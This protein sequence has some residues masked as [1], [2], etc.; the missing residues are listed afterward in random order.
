LLLVYPTY[1]RQPIRLCGEA[2]L[3]G[4]LIGNVERD[5]ITR[6]VST[7][8]F[9]WLTVA[10]VT[11]AGVIWLSMLGTVPVVRISRAIDIAVP[12]WYMATAFPILGMLVADIAML[13]VSY[14][15]GL[16]WIELAGQIIVLVIVSSLRLSLKLPISGHALLFSYFILR[17]AVIP[18]PRHR[19]RKLESAIA[20]G[21]LLIVAYVK[22]FSWGDY[23][24]LILGV[25]IAAVMA[26]ISYILVGKRQ[27]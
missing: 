14:R 21:L 23:L 6:A 1:V 3:V 13:W 19:S 17:R 8:H 9:R 7:Q 22:I 26:W 2:S 10:V 5:R 4:A 15:S 16:Y 24:T 25:G 27:I 18:I 11:V 12:F 20:I